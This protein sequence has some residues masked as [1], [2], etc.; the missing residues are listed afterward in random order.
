NDYRPR[1]YPLLHHSDDDIL[2]LTNELPFKAAKYSL[3]CQPCIHLTQQQ[4]KIL[5]KE[6][7]EKVTDL[8]DK[9]NSYMFGDMPFDK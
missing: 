3:E 5:T 4:F 2:D 7:I 8:E 9:T 1:A 6:D